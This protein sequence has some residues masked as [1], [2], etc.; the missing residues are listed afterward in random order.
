MF[1]NTAWKRHGCYSIG[2]TQYYDPPLGRSLIGCK[3]PWN[4]LD[5]FDPTA[6]T[7]R[8][9]AHFLYLRTKYDAFQDGW[10]LTT[11]RNWT[12][13]IQRPGSNGTATEMGLWSVSR[14][15]LEG[16][17]DGADT[18]PK[19]WLFYTNQNATTTWEYDCS[20]VDQYIKSPYQGGNNVRNLFYPYETISLQNSAESYYNDSK[21]PYFGCFPNIT[22]PPFG[23][24]A[25]VLEEDWIQPMPALTK[26]TPGHDARKLSNESSIQITLE[27]NLEMSC[28]S[29]TESISLNM[30]SSGTGSTPTFGTASCTTIN[31]ATPPA[32]VYGVSVSTWSWSATLENIPDGILEITVNNPS[33]EDGTA[34]T[35]VSCHCH[36]SALHFTDVDAGD[37][38]PLDPQGS[39]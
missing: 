33:T 17:Q 34:S 29:V 2:T 31:N 10:G 7:R 14:T 9:F 16:Y 19:I 27:F 35:N 13:S 3:D 24:K 30:S 4:A 21:S 36:I 39:R 11:L 28:S 18:A 26:F 12:Y 37:R 20:D 6:D 15:L 38:P 22:L 1:S 23:Y 32:E 25:Y 8:L 5:H